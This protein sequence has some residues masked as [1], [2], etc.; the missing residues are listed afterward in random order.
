MLQFL[1]KPN[2]PICGETSGDLFLI[3]FLGGFPSAS[4]GYSVQYSEC[5]AS[6]AQLF[7]GCWS[8]GDG[9]SD[10]A[11]SQRIRLGE[12]VHLTLFPHRSV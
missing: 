10:R 4:T 5:T 12:M 11:Q 2:P 7:R 9:L 6:T 8:A 3:L 1:I